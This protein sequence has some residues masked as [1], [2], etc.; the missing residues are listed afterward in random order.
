MSESSGTGR[1]P[2]SGA[3]L[4]TEHVYDPDGAYRG[5]VA[6]RRRVEPADR[7]R[8]RVVQ[9][10]EPS[11]DLDGHP[12]AAFAGDWIF[13]LQVDGPRRRYLGPDVMGAATEWQPGTMTGRG[14]WPRFGYEFESYSVL[15]AP[16]RQLTGGFFSLA[17]RSVADIVGVAVPES[18]GVEPRLDLSAPVPEVDDRWPLHRTV[19]PLLAALGQPSPLR[20]RRLWAMR[21]PIGA[22]G[23]ELVEDASEHGRV[24]SV[25]VG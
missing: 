22:S 1:D 17:G 13:E 23:F 21:D 9:H 12:M 24:V 5:S 18:S 20:R 15:V 6:Q 10:C 16:D 4:V 3:W 19:G 2:F 7:G 11:P 8:V 25:A 14:I